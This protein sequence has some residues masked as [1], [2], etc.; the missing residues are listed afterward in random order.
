MSVSIPLA[1]SRMDFQRAALQ[2]PS[3]EASLCARH[4]RFKCRHCH[5]DGGG[6][7]VRVAAKRGAMRG[8]ELC[9]RVSGCEQSS[10]AL[11]W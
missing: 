3:S 7:S 9:R 1:R 6:A 4:P 11:R 8:S 2:F 10:K 5:E